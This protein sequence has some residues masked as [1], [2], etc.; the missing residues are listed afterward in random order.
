MIKGCTYINRNRDEGK[1]ALSRELKTAADSVRVLIQLEELSL[2]LEGEKREIRECLRQNLS[3]R[4]VGEV[5][6][7][8]LRVTRQSDATRWQ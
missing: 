6:A 8:H 3:S 1:C 5:T 4:Q 7:L 2:G